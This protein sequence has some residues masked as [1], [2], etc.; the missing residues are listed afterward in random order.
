MASEKTYRQ[1]YIENKTTREDIIFFVESFSG[2]SKELLDQLGFSYLEY[3]TMLAHPRVFWGD[4]DRARQEYAN[5]NQTNGPGRQSGV[6]GND[7][8]ERN[9]WT[10]ESHHQL[11]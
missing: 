9:K 10:P 8:T 2:T 11:V 7:Q 4:L 6:K 1:L 5:G 3:R